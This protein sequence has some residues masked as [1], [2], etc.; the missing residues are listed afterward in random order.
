MV[1]NLPAFLR[2]LVRVKDDK[3]RQLFEPYELDNIVESAMS[4][5]YPIISAKSWGISNTKKG[6][7]FDGKN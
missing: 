7:V 4:E 6:E 2:S 3:G 5:Q 1:E